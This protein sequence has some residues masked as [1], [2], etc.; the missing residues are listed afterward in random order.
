MKYQEKVST[1]AD[2]R[3]L[4]EKVKANPAVAQYRGYTE[5]KSYGWDEAMDDYV[6]CDGEVWFDNPTFDVSFTEKAVLV[7]E[8]SEL[9]DEPE[10]ANENALLALEEECACLQDALKAVKAELEAVK[11][12]RDEAVAKKDAACAILCN[13]REVLERVL[14]YQPE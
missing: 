5:S 1:R 3:A 8:E 13:L 14:S 9:L 10:E 7:D 4:F 2:V 6:K 12:A 11:L